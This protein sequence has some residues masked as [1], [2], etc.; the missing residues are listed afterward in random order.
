MMERIRC[1]SSAQKFP[2][3]SNV[4]QCRRKDCAERACEEVKRFVFLQVHAARKEETQM[5]ALDA[6]SGDPQLAKPKAGRCSAAGSKYQARLADIM[7]N[8]PT[9]D[10][11]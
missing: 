1:G 3:V 4:W 6:T 2:P 7:V 11:M 9:N 10:L 5:E 8:G